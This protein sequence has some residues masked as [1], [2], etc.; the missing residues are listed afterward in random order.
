MSHRHPLKKFLIPFLD[1][2]VKPFLI[3]ALCVAGLVFEFLIELPFI[4]IIGLQRAAN[5]RS[6]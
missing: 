3:V 1:Q 5:G 2:V 6:R 4:V